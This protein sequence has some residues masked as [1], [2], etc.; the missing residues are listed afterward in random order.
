MAYP[1]P[2]RLEYMALDALQPHPENPKGHDEEGIAASM[3]R[4]GVIDI[5]VLDDR[6][7]QLIS[8]HGRVESFRRLRDAGKPPPDGVT[9]LDDG[10][11]TVP[12]VRGWASKDDDEAQTALIG[13]NQGTIAGGWI[14]DKLAMMLGDLEA[15]GALTGTFF[16]PADVDL[17]LSDVRAPDVIGQTPEG[18]WQGMPEYE[19]NDLESKHRLIVH[20][21][22]DE[23]RRKF[24]AMLGDPTPRQNSIWWPESDGHVGEDWKVQ[25]VSEEEP[26]GAD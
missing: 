20:F 9:V 18:E 25:Y 8:G 10:T 2:R 1:S 7:E 4:L 15:K 19:S 22:S 17:L 5:I 26:A 12:V 21:P 14:P 13:L 24:L 23:D 6:T 3:D 11:W 16:T